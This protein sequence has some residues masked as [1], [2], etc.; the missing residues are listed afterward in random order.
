MVLGVVSLC[1]D[2]EIIEIQMEDQQWLI[3]PE[4]FIASLVWERERREKQIKELIMP[5]TSPQL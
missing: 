3:Q 2:E 1:M 4:V 5:R